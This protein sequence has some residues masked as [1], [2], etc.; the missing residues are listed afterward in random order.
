METT[1]GQLV[2]NES[3]PE[4]MR[5]YNRVWDKKT[6]GKV[7]TELAY[8]HPDK[9][10]DVAHDLVQFGKQ[11]AYLTG[12]QS[13]SLKDMAPT[14][15]TKTLQSQLNKETQ[16]I[17]S[18][19][20]ASGKSSDDPSVKKAIVE[21]ALRWQPKV[22]QATDD[23]S[24]MNNALYRQAKGTGAAKGTSYN[25][26]RGADLLY[27][28][29]SNKPVP[30]P[31]T[32]GYAQGLTPVEYF[33]GSFGSRKGV[34][35][36]QNATRD[37]GSLSKQLVQMAHRLVVV[38]DDDADSYDETS[39]V[40]LPSKVD[41]ADNEGGFLAL[42]VAGYKRNTLLTPKIMADMKRRGVKNILVR[43]VIAGGPGN[44]GI[45]AYDAGL[46]ENGGIPAVGDFVGI[47]AVQSISEPITQSAI[48]SKHSG[49]VLG[50]AAGKTI[51]GFKYINQ[52]L[53]VPK[54]FPNGATHSDVSGIVQ[55]IR[56]APQGG[57]YV[58]ID[59]QEHYVGLNQ[60]EQ[61]PL[62][63]K[64]GDTVEAGDVISDG[65]PNPATIVKYKGIGEGRRYF[66][67][68]FN[69]ALKDQGTSVNRRNVEAL[70][71]GLI[72]YVRLND[73]VGDFSPGDVA[74]Y[75]MIAADW[76][77]REG[78]VT[79][80]PSQC[81]GMYLEKPVLHYTIG[82]P[83][84]RSVINE[85]NEFGIKNIVAHKDAPPFESEMIRGMAHAANDPDW[86]T[87]MLGGYNKNSL[88]EATRRGGIS[89]TYGTSF[90]PA[91]AFGGSDFGHVGATRQEARK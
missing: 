83:I 71:R 77:P 36:L 22:L 35:D 12:G 63:V 40:G 7:L 66:V 1:I 64:V 27:V 33:A 44:G 13:F 56:E 73:E 52:M 45:Y 15:Y 34:V 76:K 49:G 28:D 70:S 74:P 16:N 59:G 88:L 30:I 82:T 86:G 80:A 32:H 84:R 69:Q 47:N 65:I 18:R 6:S 78:A 25:S 21:A 50:A 20:Y 10:K 46:R 89:N 57:K 79:A 24:D 3:L 75:C 23:E 87:R 72:N 60:G 48:S 2:I 58:S 42:P 53:Q 39:P 90:V 85:L 19:A 51:S 67:N 5:D 38:D 4:D 11:S 37:S 55:L 81:K 8:R 14:K 91:I 41:D 61:V 17:L 54:H 29:H 43:S 26:I 68:Q 62:K 9:Y 31:V